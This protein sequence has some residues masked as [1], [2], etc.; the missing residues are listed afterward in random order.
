MVTFAELCR[1][2]VVPILL[3]T[4]IAGIGRWRAWVWMMPLAAGAAFLAGYALLLN[5]V[6]RLPPRD[7]TDWLFWAAIP[8]TLLGVVESLLNKR[9]GWILGAIAGGVAVLVAWPLVPRTV[10][11]LEAIALGASLAIIGAAV[12]FV[13]SILEARTDS[14]TIIASQCL[15]IGAA[16]VVILSSNLRIVGIYGMAASAA[17]VPVAI[18]TKTNFRAACGVT[19][20]AIPIL[21]GLLVGGRYYPDPG[22]SWLQVTILMLAPALPLAGLLIPGQQHPRVRS[23]LML[24]IVALVAAVVALPPAMEAK[25]AA[26][27]NTYEGY[28]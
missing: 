6:P 14:F 8:V 13:A 16:A 22:V 27:E 19:I 12:C 3:A 2:V 26:E 4:L 11:M 5:G 24:V 18:L 15:I 21:A 1:A 17:L 25:R 20:V 28:Y 7:G 9:W 10:P 23:L